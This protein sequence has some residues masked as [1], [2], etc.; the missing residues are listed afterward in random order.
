MPS[1]GEGDVVAVAGAREALVSVL[2]ADAEEVED[3]ELLAMPVEGVDVLCHQQGGR[4]QDARGPPPDAGNARL[5]PA[6]D[7]ARRHR[8]GDPNPAQHDD[9]ARRPVHHCRSDGGHRQ[10]RQAA[11][12]PR[13]C[14]RHHR[15]GVRRPGVVIGALFGSLVFD[16]GGVPL[17]P[18][19]AG[20]ALVAG[21]IGGWLRPSA[22]DSGGSRRRPSGS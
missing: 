8:D 6:E 19:T 11:G 17:T 1:C 7:H 14:D 15:H 13:S 21:I 5:L 3:R 18:S 2:G 9:S 10:C 22:P 4:R 20:G 12:G 16:I